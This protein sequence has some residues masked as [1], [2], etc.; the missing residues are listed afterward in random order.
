MA[1]ETTENDAIGDSKSDPNGI[2]G[3]PPVSTGGAPLPPAPA[4]VAPSA[5]ATPAAPAANIQDDIA[6]IL[7]G[8]KLPERRSE[9]SA[10]QKKFD[11]A[12]GASVD[13]Q[14]TLE[15]AAP[16]ATPKQEGISAVHTLK[17]DLQ[18]VV[19]ENK[20][21]LVR[22]AA[23]EQEK[24]RP[25]PL[26][27]TPMKSRRPIAGMLILIAILMLLGAGA[28][29]GVYYIAQP[30][31]QTTEQVTDSLIFAETA[32]SLPLNG[33]S[34]DAL[35]FEL[36]RLRLAGSSSLGAITHVVPTV[37]GSA[38]AESERVATFAE[39]LRAIEAQAPEG[40]TRALSDE[41]FLGLHTVDKNATI[42]I[43]PVVSYDH[44][45]SSM[46]QWEQTMNRALASLFTE[47]PPLVVDQNGAVAQRTFVDEINR[48]FDV[49][50]LKSESGEMILYYSFPTREL[51][52]IA[53]SPYSFAEILSRLQAARRL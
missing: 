30:S 36:A 13:K 35:R 45:F 1:D 18:E 22:A 28:L 25:E 40:L 32:S 38:P 37:A 12:L 50:A 46:L 10:P 5:P 16:G 8:T 48:N 34:A 39:F 21:S 2:P 11:T 47:I 24:R 49:R 7:S 27:D 6:K 4:P 42:I 3:A 44:A 26:D 53:E 14:P 43:V 19:A 9:E 33:Q 23:L 51:L 31:A 17:H 15:T 41:F 29:F 20:I 52:V